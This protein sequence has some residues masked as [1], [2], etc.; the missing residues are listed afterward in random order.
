MVKKKKKA[1]LIINSKHIY[2]LLLNCIRQVLQSFQHVLF[3]S[4][5]H[6][7]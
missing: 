3:S 7:A 1:N 6:K 2:Q 4:L 5:E